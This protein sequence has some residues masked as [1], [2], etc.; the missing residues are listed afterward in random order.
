MKKVNTIAHWRRISNYEIDIIEEGDTSHVILLNNDK[1]PYG[2]ITVIDYPSYINS[3]SSPLLNWENLIR[4]SNYYGLPPEEVDENGQPGYMSLAVQ[5]HLKPAATLRYNI[6]DPL[7]KCLKQNLPDDCSIMRYKEED[8][9]F[10]CRDC[11]LADLFDIDE[12]RATYERYGI[13]NVEWKTVRELSEKNLSYFSDNSMS[14]ISIEQGAESIT[15]AVVL[16]LLLGYPIESTV[17]RIKGTYRTDVFKY[18]AKNH[19]KENSEPYVDADGEQWF[20]DKNCVF[21]SW[22]RESL[23]Y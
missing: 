22:Q 5:Q 13:Q 14:G 8:T 1:H 11:S 23:Y 19:F 6:D 21:A 9:T 16:G 12:V 17:A 7:I 4:C 3:F 2:I 20:K 18:H 10:I 15:Q